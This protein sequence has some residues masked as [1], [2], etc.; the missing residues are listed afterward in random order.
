MRATV[1]VAICL[2]IMGTSISFAKNMERVIARVNLEVAEVSDAIE[3]TMY[4]AARILKQQRIL[5]EQ[6]MYGMS[7]SDVWVNHEKIDGHIQILTQEL[8]RAS[9]E[10][11]PPIHVASAKLSILAKKGHLKEVIAQKKAP[12]ELQH[13]IDH[14]LYM[15][16]SMA[17]WHYHVK[18]IQRGSKGLSSS[19]QNTSI[20]DSINRALDSLFAESRTLVSAT[21]PGLLQGLIAARDICSGEKADLSFLDEQGTGCANCSGQ[22]CGNCMLPP[23]EHHDLFDFGCGDECGH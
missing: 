1:L 9:K 16:E 17:M 23:G 18:E 13:A 6:E 3:G 19:F 8:H 14:L 10:Y 20:I 11:L 7:G 21:F 12:A 15:E 4:E 2:L 5:L 22:G